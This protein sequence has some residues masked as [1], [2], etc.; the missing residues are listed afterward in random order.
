MPA[1]VIAQIEVNDQQEYRKYQ[2]AFKAASEKFGCRVLVATNYMELLEG[3]W[4]K[5]RN[6]VMEYPSM[7]LAREWYKSKDYQNI[8]HHRHRSSMTNM[9]LVD[10]FPGL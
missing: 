9:I 6:V 7:E 5:V 1:Y 8:I 10:G 2:L 3:N 4:P